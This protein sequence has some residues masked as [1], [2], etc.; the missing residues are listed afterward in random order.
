MTARMVLI[1]PLLFTASVLVGCGRAPRDLSGA[2]DTRTAQPTPADKTSSAPGKPEPVKA[3]PTAV[4]YKTPQECGE[5]FVASAMRGDHKTWAGCFA[6]QTV[7]EMAGDDALRWVMIRRNT[8]GPIPE[9]VKPIFA[10]LD[11]HGLTVQAT[12]A[13]KDVKD[14]TEFEKGRKAVLALMKDP[15]EYMSDAMAV[16]MKHLGPKGGDEVRHTFVDVKING[17]AATATNVRTTRLGQ[18]KRTISFV[19]IDGGWRILNDK[20]EEKLDRSAK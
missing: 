11:K 20:G 3:G 13:I 6:P 7:A 14:P 19:K 12:A 2:P 9:D 8:S 17:D 5:A 10:L 16:M 4:V 1:V 15:A 18:Q